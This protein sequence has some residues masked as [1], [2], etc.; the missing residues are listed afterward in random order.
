MVVE[1][2]LLNKLKEEVSSIDYLL[3]ASLISSTHK[4]RVSDLYTRAEG[5]AP[6]TLCGTQEM[7][8]IL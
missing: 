5:S 4:S 8:L 2:I 6:K 7:V 1:Q 3:V